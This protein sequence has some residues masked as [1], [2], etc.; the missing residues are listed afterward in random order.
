MSSP[1]PPWGVMQ[2]SPYFQVKDDIKMTKNKK[3]SFPAQGAAITPGNP[4]PFFLE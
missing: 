4:L 3:L 2:I 1:D